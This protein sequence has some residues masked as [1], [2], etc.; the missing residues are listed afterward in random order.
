MTLILKSL[1]NA[2][3]GGL[4]T[5]IIWYFANDFTRIKGVGW[6]ERQP[7]PVSSQWLCVAAGATAA[8]LASAIALIVARQRSIQLKSALEGLGF[9]VKDEIQKSDLNL[10]RKVYGLDN[11]KGGYNHAQGTINGVK[12]QLLE[13]HQQI[14]RTRSEGPET[15][16]R[17]HSVLLLDL[18]ENT[19]APVQLIRQAW[20][21]VFSDSKGVILNTDDLFGASTD[22]ELLSKFN[23]IFY[24]SPPDRH[25]SAGPDYVQSIQ[26]IVQIPFVQAVMNCRFKW[27]LEIT[28][29]QMA[30]WQHN[31]RLSA[32]DVRSAIEEAIQIRKAY[33]EPVRSTTR[34]TATS[35]FSG[36]MNL[37]VKAIIGGAIAGML[38]AFASFAPIF[39]LFVDKA[40]WI[41]FVWP[42]Y[43]MAIVALCIF[44]SVKVFGDKD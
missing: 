3:P 41:V 4:M 7:W 13:L 8:T 40:R 29:D 15:I 22:K 19:C 33:S 16:D 31:K 21:P 38:L 10:P 30:L 14:H 6:L 1:A 27:N 36:G 26:P 9:V 44:L 11:W 32:S 37:P 42:F 35:H 25:D 23:D 20:S 43:G 34:V 28:G 2:I 24:I 39:F 5:W 12:V 18:P 17:H